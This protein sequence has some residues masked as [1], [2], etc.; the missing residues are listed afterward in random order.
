MT[1]SQ[2]LLLAGDMA[3]WLIIH[4]GLQGRQ[5]EALVRLMYG[6][7]FSYLKDVEAVLVDQIHLY[8]T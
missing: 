4:L 1:M 3:V 7:N 2:K 8:M 6:A 5:Q